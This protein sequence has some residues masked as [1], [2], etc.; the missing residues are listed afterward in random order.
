VAPVRRQTTLFGQVHRVAA[1]GAKSAVSDCILFRMRTLGD[2]WQRFFHGPE[3]FP[4][5]NVK[6]LKNTESKALIN[7]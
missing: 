7:Q 3:A 5:Y 2:K 1:L 6:A 4:V